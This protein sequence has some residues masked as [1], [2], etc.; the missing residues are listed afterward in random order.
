MFR[1][2]RKLRL[3]GVAAVAASALIAA[4]CSSSGSSNSSGGTAGTKVTGGTARIGLQAGITY[5]YIFPF[6]PIT[7]AGVYND[8]QFQS[9]MYRP[10]YMFGANNPTNVTINYPL[11]T[12]SA[13]SWNHWTCRQAGSP[14]GSMRRQGSTAA[15]W[16]AGRCL[17]C[18]TTPGTRRRCG[19]CCPE[20]PPAWY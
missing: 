14:G 16:Q 4:A 3:A 7:Y 11:S 10:L 12:R 9:L 15:C 8:N 2:R 5:S 6:Y 1:R 13:C 19:R 18:S 20:F 17:S